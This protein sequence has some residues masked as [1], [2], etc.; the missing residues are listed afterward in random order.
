MAPKK[1]KTVPLWDPYETLNV[2]PNGNHFKCLEPHCCVAI[3]EKDTDRAC[4]RLDKMALKDPSEIGEK[5]MA[6]LAVL[7]FCSEHRE[8]PMHEDEILEKVSEW[9]DRID[10][11]LEER[12]RELKKAKKAKKAKKKA[13]QE[14]EREVNRLLEEVNGLKEKLQRTVDENGTMSKKIPELQKQHSEVESAKNNLQSANTVYAREKEQLEREMERIRKFAACSRDIKIKEVDELKIQ[15]RDSGARVEEAARHISDLKGQLE[16]CNARIESIKRETLEE[17]RELRGQLDRE[18]GITMELNELTSQLRESNTRLEEINT[19][20]EESNT[21]LEGSKSLHEVMERQTTAEINNLRDQLDQSNTS[22]R[23]MRQGLKDELTRCK[24]VITGLKAAGSANIVQLECEADR[25]N[26]VPTDYQ[27]II[28][29]GIADSRQIIDNDNA[30]EQ[31]KAANS[32]EKNQVTEEVRGQREQLRN[33]KAAS[34]NPTSVLQPK[35]QKSK[36]W[37]HIPVRRSQVHFLFKQRKVKQ[38]ETANPA[39][40]DNVLSL[41]EQARAIDRCLAGQVVGLSLLSC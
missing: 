27:T 12:D 33:G 40:L 22:L 24:D 14:Q 17:I 3:G 29:C 1:P 23:N 26:C 38:V 9:F 16:E 21:R 39:L 6:R 10:E 8:D 19:N 11:F 35:A 18:R 37:R 7:R 30:V 13:K 5:S 28:G 15:L 34:T 4:A 36:I 32:Y 20:L 25:C 41:R 2:F 31:S